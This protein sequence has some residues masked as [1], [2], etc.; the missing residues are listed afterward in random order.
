[1][2]KKFLFVGSSETWNK[3][4]K[5][6]DEFPQLTIIPILESKADQ[7]L[8]KLSLYAVDAV[9]TSM[10]ESSMIRKLIPNNKPVYELNCSP[11][12]LYSALSKWLFSKRETNEFRVS[13]DYTSEEDIR[14]QVMEENLSLNR[15]KIKE[16]KNDMAVDEILAYHEEGM[17]TKQVQAILTIHPYIY[18]S[19]KSRHMDVHLITPTYSCIRNDLRQM[20]DQ[21]G[22]FNLVSQ[23]YPYRFENPK[24]LQQI[25]NTGVSGATIH[26]L[27]CLCKSLGRDKLT[28]AELAKGFAITLRSARRILTTLEN[29]SIA[30]VVGEEQLK[31]RGRPRYVYQV[32]FTGFE[33]GMTSL[34]ALG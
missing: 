18:Q 10:F 11:V 15:L 7:I 16:H 20:M 4:K 8:E 25:K 27:F 28:A 22:T 33:E 13:I 31:G 29:S 32:D 3:L 17:K 1:M 34:S 30:K 21:L 26:R 23:T 9:L 24:S 14:M 2:K 6:S 12:A 19:L 5:V